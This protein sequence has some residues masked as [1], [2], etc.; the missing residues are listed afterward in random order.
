MQIGR[1]PYEPGAVLAFYEDALTALGA[2]CSQPWHDRLEIVA[3]GRAARLWNPDGAL[4]AAELHFTP[5][6]GTGAR[7]ATREVFPGCPLT[8]RL[9][10][11]LHT[12]SLALERVALAREAAHRAPDPLVAEKLWRTQFSDT[13]RWR[14]ATPLAAGWHFSL[15]ALARC[16]IQAI[17]QHWALH[18]VAVS[19]PDGAVDDGLAREIGFARVEAH[20]PAAPAWPAPDPAGWSSLLRAALAQELA[21][22][23]AGIRARQQE[24]LRREWERIDAYFDHYVAE[25]TARAQRSASTKATERIAAAR[26]EHARHR[27]DQVA[28]HE[29]AVVPHF[30]AL[31]LVAEPAWRGR[32]HVERAHR[33]PEDH[34]A[35]FVPRARRWVVTPV[36]P[37]G[38]G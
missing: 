24:R 19:L 20:A 17:D 26:A 22:E 18:R 10:E 34:D 30:D 11:A 32:I 36:R 5:P 37:P 21:T 16:E 14:L 3:E 27:G 8:F 15:V 9:T 35:C 2:L 25:L 13:N 33:A 29:I 12:E 38:L 4:H 7:D 31:L 1:L 28:R 6:G 23:L